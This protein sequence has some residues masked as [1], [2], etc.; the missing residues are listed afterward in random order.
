MIPDRHIPPEYFTT[1]AKMLRNVRQR[2]DIADHIG[3]TAN[4]IQKHRGPDYASSSEDS[5]DEME[6]PEVISIGIPF[7][8]SIPQTENFRKF[9]E[10][11]TVR[12]YAALWKYGAD[13]FDEERIVGVPDPRSVG[14][15]IHGQSWVSVHR[16]MRILTQERRE[17]QVA[18][19]RSENSGNYDTQSAEED[20]QNPHTYRPATV[21]RHGK[22]V[23]PAFENFT[24][25]SEMED[26][27]FRRWTRSPYHTTGKW[28]DGAWITAKERNW[29]SRVI[30]RTDKDVDDPID[31][32]LDSVEWENA[33]R[34][35]RAVEIQQRFGKTDFTMP[36]PP[37][38]DWRNKVDFNALRSTPTVV[39]DANTHEGYARW[40]VDDIDR[41][42]Q[43]LCF[44][45]V[46][47]STLQRYDA[48]FRVWKLWS[49]AR[50]FCDQK[51]IP[52]SSWVYNGI[53]APRSS[54]EHCIARDRLASFFA[55]MWKY[56]NK[57]KS[58]LQSTLQAIVHVHKSFGISLDEFH[59][60]YSRYIL[61]SIEKATKAPRVNEPAP[62][63]YLIEILATYATEIKTDTKRLEGIQKR[64]KRMALLCGLMWFGLLRISEIV[65]YSEKK[66]G[67]KA[68]L[69]SDVWPTLHGQRMANTLPETWKNCNGFLMFIR[70]SKTDQRG[71]GFARLFGQSGDAIL[72]PVHIMKTYVLMDATAWIQ[73]TDRRK[74][75]LCRLHTLGMGLQRK[76]LPIFNNHVKNFILKTVKESS[77]LPPRLKLT[78]HSFRAGGA[79]ALLMSGVDHTVVMTL[80]RWKSNAFTRYVMRAIG[81]QPGPEEEMVQRN[82]EPLTWS[83]V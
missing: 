53:M 4:Y 2:S 15:P 11:D 24:D 74:T 29:K 3:R 63:D 61:K 80:G 42:K 68:L 25:D 40:M 21:R 12:Y 33:E 30:W 17:R 31:I 82:V 45:S 27:S 49:A 16:G 46:A 47:D 32:L 13:S 14:I 57:N 60:G 9:L 71:E 65:E 52:A 39:R 64:F 50:E 67:D 77:V 35:Q 66:P 38:I 83:F 76:W 37:K 78:P 10:E 26:E 41:T 28:L 7:G 72:C 18:R 51:G 36:T 79:T 59:L 69:A 75:P 73:A 19:E 20:A 55:Y 6:T 43:L 1:K 8:K 62:R 34:R 70:K 48:H 44:S 56:V 54:I 22:F 81:S 58:F 5:L 23:L